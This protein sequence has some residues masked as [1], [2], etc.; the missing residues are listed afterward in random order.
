MFNPKS[1]LLV[2]VIVIST[3]SA[4]YKD[5]SGLSEIDITKLP[6]VEFMT[7]SIYGRVVDE[8]DQSIS[9][10]IITLML[11]ADEI[12]STTDLFGHFQF[13]GIENYGKSAFLSI[14]ADGKF[15]A[16]RRLSVIEN[17]GNYTEVKMMEK[18]IIGSVNTVQGGSLANADGAEIELP[19][20]GIVS[21]SGAVYDG[22][23]SVAMQ[24]IDPTATDLAS[25]MIGD[26]SAIDKDGNERALATYGMLQIELLDPAGNELNLAQEAAA[27]LQFPVPAALQSHAPSTIPLWSYDEE[28]G[29]WIEEGS[30]N[31]ENGVYRGEV[32]HFSSWNVD[33][34]FDP[35]EVKGKVQLKITQ[36]SI[37]ASYLSIYVES[38]EI[39]RKGGWL[40]GDGAFSFYNFPKGEV[41]DLLIF[42]ECQ[43]LLLKKEY[44][45]FESDTDLGCIEM[46]DLTSSQIIYVFGNVTNCTNEKVTDGLAIVES[47]D[48][49]RYYELGIDGSFEFAIDVCANFESSITILDRRTLLETTLLVD[50]SQPSWAFSNTV[51]CTPYSDELISVSIDG[52]DPVIA[53]SGF[54]YARSDNPNGVPIVDIYV[55]FQDTVINNAFSNSAASEIYLKFSADEAL[56]P[57][58]TPALGVDIRSGDLHLFADGVDQVEISISTYENYVGGYIE[59]MF[60]GVVS[61]LNTGASGIPINGVFRVGID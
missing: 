20:N 50:A 14:K 31:Y 28:L 24:W 26:L 53:L 17:R 39:G 34:P 51:L 1:F 15:E 10:A 60:S 40:C 59:G 44:G 48:N 36:K 7:T 22:E 58:T 45:P 16:F 54:Q 27:I 35:I 19:A 49:L 46:E 55:G 4:C 21:A 6:P 8:N 25:R 47:G 23:V 43:N 56:V 11:G 57:S 52:A 61:D 41:F 18:N 13:Y 9:N 42:D 12:V 30:A 38:D 5:H 3:F 37:D 29:K 33:F 32:S 2:F